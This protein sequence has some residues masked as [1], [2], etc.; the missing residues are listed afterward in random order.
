MDLG[1][2]LGIVGTVITIISF[3]YAIL[4]TRQSR[5]IKKLVYSKL[6][7]API[8]GAISKESGY[9]ISI[10]YEESLAKTRIVE[11]V[12]VQY[13]RFA[14]IGQTPI[15]GTDSAK[16]DPL[17]IEIQGGNILDVTLAA[18][19]REVCQISIP[20]LVEQDDKAISVISFDFL[21]NLDGGL[22]QIVS[23]GE[24]AKAELLGTVIG[25]PE[26]VTKEE[27]GKTS[28]T[29]PDLGCVIPIIV[30]AVALIAV[31]YLYYYFNGSWNGIALLLLPVGAMSIPFILTLPISIM[32]VSRS[33]INFPKSLQPPSWY[34]SRYD[35]YMNSAYTTWRRN[36]KRQKEISKEQNR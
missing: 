21:D 14:N 35:L 15:M 33:G 4:V 28:I 34:N 5:K 10:V 19:T 16:G 18:V 29:F 31:P 23:E 12:Y 2:A 25:M 9:A 26:G 20:S 24:N 3:I 22:I 13:I 30:Q 8:A 11:G 7:P 17:R 6:P 27:L 36:S 1:L 32:L